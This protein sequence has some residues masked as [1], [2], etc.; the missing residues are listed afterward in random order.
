MNKTELKREIISLIESKRE[1]EYWDFKYCHHSNKANLLHDILCMANNRSNNDGYIIFG[2]EDKTFKIVGVENNENRLNQQNII[3]FLRSKVFFMDIRPE[4][5]LVTFTAEQHQVDV[6]IIYNTLNTPYYLTDEFKEKDRSVKENHIYTRV[7]DT[8]TAINKNA[9][10]NHIEYLWKKRFGLHLS[11]FEKL[12]YNLNQ[13][14]KWVSK[15]SYHYNIVNPEYTL[16]FEDDYTVSCVS[17]FY[18][19]IMTNKSASYGELYAKYFETILYEK[20][21]VHLDGGRFTTV[22][23][24]S[25]FI[26][27]DKYNQNYYV[28]K[29]FIKD[30]ISYYLHRYLID[31]DSEESISAYN[32]FIEVVLFFENE[33]EKECFIDYVKCNIDMIEGIEFNSKVICDD[34]DI[35]NRIKVAKKF[36]EIQNRFKAKYKNF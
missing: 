12:K 13:K 24:E 6:L 2:I 25:E 36:K 31:E 32:L 4:I 9:D 15:G 28:F 34:I 1:G 5:E 10:P 29:Y 18:A 21:I 11:P 23:P 22:V 30:D 16:T 20:Q 14:S 8:N 19:N 27:L 35:S 3:D 7:G 33:D 17:E 26:Y